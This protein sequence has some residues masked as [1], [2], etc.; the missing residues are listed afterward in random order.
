MMKQTGIWIDKSKALIVNLIGDKS[1]IEEINSE[2]ETK[3]RF[4]GETKQFGKFGGQFLSNQEKK[5]HREIEQKK[6]FLNHLLKQIQASDQI[7]VLG[8]AEMKNELKKL[9][10]NDPDFKD[11]LRGIES[12]DN[13]T[14][15][16]LVAW[17]KNYFEPMKSKVGHKVS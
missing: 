17:V 11:K 6:K 12:V 13:M 16:Q 5:E 14:N 9:I 8:P 2:I 7:V 1:E 15:N 10:L 4:E 3:V